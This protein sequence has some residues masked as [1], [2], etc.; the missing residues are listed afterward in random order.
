[1]LVLYIPLVKIS[2]KI[3]KGMHRT[4]D[5]CV[6]DNIEDC[7]DESTCERDENFVEIDNDLSE[8]RDTSY[9]QD[10]AFIPS[11]DEN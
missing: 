10:E 3:V 9:C 1:M 5:P 4:S 11:N 2:E 6:A 8:D 7:Q